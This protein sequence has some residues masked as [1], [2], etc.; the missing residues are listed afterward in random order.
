MAEKILNWIYIIALYG[1]SAIL[2]VGL[3]LASKKPMVLPN[4][5]YY[6]GLISA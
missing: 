4:L 6:I 5:D 3:Y 2:L 1:L